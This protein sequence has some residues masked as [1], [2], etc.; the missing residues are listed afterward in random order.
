MTDIKKSTTTARTPAALMPGCKY[1]YLPV[2]SC[3]DLYILLWNINPNNINKLTSDQARAIFKQAAKLLKANN[4][5]M[6]AQP[7]A[8]KK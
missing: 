3:E 6:P 8:K 7:K 1:K 2:K 4:W 5:Q